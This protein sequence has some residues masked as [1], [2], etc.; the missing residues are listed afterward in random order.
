[1]VERRPLL[2]SNRLSH[3]AVKLRLGRRGLTGELVFGAH[4][5]GFLWVTDKRVVLITN[6]HNVTGWPPALDR[7]LSNTGFVPQFVQ[8]A[9][10]LKKSA[11]ENLVAVDRR[12]ATVDLFDET[13][14]AKWLEHPQHGRNVD[15]VALP[16]AEWVEEV[17]T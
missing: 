5:T 3:A 12:L 13:N 14:G 2:I 6:W 1:M 16:V 11:G 8:F 10:N 17:L 4:A 7:S 15:V 9:I